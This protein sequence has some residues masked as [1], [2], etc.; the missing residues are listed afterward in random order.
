MS[1][2]E[3]MIGQL[4]I[5]AIM[6]GGLLVG[7]LTL[8]STPVYAHVVPT[9]CDFT[10]GGGFVITDQG[11]HANFGLVAGCKHGGFFGHF[12][13]V[14]HDTSGFFAGLHVSS[15]QITG[16]FDPCIGGCGKPPPNHPEISLKRN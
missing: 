11:N 13:F 15:T 14:D 8:R 1:K 7:L 12:N 16:Y 10:T 5:L 6:A 4:A 3:K 9:P 2:R